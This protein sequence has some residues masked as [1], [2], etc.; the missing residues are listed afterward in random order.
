MRL[1]AQTTAQRAVVAMGR[2]G[3][4]RMLRV[5]SLWAAGCGLGAAAGGV[6]LPAA[7]LLAVLVFLGWGNAW[8]VVAGTDWFG[9]LA[10]CWPPARPVALPALPYMQPGSPAGRL[11]R[12][13]GRVL[14]W[15]QTAFW[16]ALSAPILSLLAALAL[17][18]ALLLLL[19]ER[20]AMLHVALAAVLGLVLVWRRRGR[21]PLGAQAVVQVGLPWLAGHLVVA[22]PSGLS[23]VLA[24]CFSLAAWGVLRVAHKGGGL[25]LLNGGLVLALAALAAARQPLAAAL[26]G[27]LFFGQLALQPSLRHGADPASIAGRT[28]PWLLAAMALAALATP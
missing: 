8:D 26:V 7:A 16:P 23:W 4:G 1:A 3:A 20:L 19:P 21:R 13:L 17:V 15:W 6:G 9:P 27:L 18:G 10:G 11:V 5:A 12:A 22:P 28:W 2:P 14:G 25:L 24:S